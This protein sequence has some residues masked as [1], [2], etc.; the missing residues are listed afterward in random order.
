[1]TTASSEFLFPSVRFD[2]YGLSNGLTVILHE[3]RSVPVA[4]VVVMYHVGSKN[5]RPGRTGF[6]HLFEHLMF[7]GSEHVADGD[8]FRLLQEIGANVNGSTTEDRTNYYEILPSQHLELALY[9]ESDRM[10]YLLPSVTQNKLDNQREVVKNERRQNYD[11]QP[12][13]TVPEKIAKV[14]YPS[15]HP[16]HWPVIG[17]M[18]DLSAASLDDVREFFRLY[19]AP[20][21]ACISI[22]GNFEPGLVREW[23]DRYF[24]SIPAGPSLSRPSPAPPVLS[25][26]RRFFMEDRVTLPRLLIAW[27]SFPRGTR[28]DAVMDILTSILSSGKGSH[29]YKALVLDQQI[30]QSVVAYQDGAEIAGRTTI[31]VTAKPNTPLTLI[32]QSVREVLHNLDEETVTGTEIQ[33][34]VNG[35]EARVVA[36]AATTY[37]RA[38]G[39]ASAFTLVGN[40]DTYN[41]ELQRFQDLSPEEILAVSRRILGAG[42]VVLSV[43]PAGELTLAA[44]ASQNISLAGA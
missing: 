16:Y 6:A 42:A 33:A 29:L 37:G 14:L 27:H 40:T 44:D 36:R 15:D 2:Q 1:V 34:A 32:E 10:G 41:K 5:E 23:I 43:V 22:A 35:V 18:Q 28:G 31:E 12:Y 7:K 8:H 24:A 19:Y 17:S 38:N 3:D 21:N 4:A 26:D 11:N 25:T 20:N 39:L 9:L 30:A 13:G